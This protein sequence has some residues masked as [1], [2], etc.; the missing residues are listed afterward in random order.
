MKFLTKAQTIMYSILILISGL[1]ARTIAENQFLRIPVILL[2]VVF[3]ITLLVTFFRIEFSK[4]K[5][6]KVRDLSEEEGGKIKTALKDDQNALLYTL[7]SAATLLFSVFMFTFILKSGVFTLEND[8]LGSLIGWLL[9]ISSIVSFVFLAR[10]LFRLDRKERFTKDLENGIV[11]IE[12]PTWRI[13]N[14]FKVGRYTFYRD[15]NI[16]ND[17]LNIENGENYY[18]EFRPGTMKVESIGKL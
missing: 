6:F 17:I 9:I 18:I 8:F 2:W 4:V 12:G 13:G 7:L 15:H 14:G 11:R 5:Y 1:G 3:S 16:L 10:S